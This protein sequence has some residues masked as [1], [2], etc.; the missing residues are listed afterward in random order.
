MACLSPE[1]NVFRLC[2]AVY[3]DRE[4]AFAV[5]LRLQSAAKSEPRLSEIQ[6]YGIL[7]VREREIIG[8]LVASEAEGLEESPVTC[9]VYRFM[10]SALGSTYA[11]PGAAV[12]EV[13]AL[14]SVAESVGI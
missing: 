9:A 1:V 5:T 10:D 12:C 8:E 11:V 7:A 6:L 3:S 13:V 4:Q 14:P 2:L